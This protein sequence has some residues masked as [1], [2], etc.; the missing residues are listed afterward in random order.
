LGK[1][2]FILF[3][4]FSYCILTLEEHYAKARKDKTYD[5]FLF[6]I[7]LDFP[8]TKDSDEGEDNVE[9]DGE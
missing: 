6:S 1:R 4:A 8:R 3:K 5:I 7:D 9:K 2:Y